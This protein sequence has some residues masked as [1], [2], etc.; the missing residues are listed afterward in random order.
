MKKVLLSLILILM[1][2]FIASGCTK[3]SVVAQQ[4]ADSIVVH[5]ASITRHEIPSGVVQVLD[6]DVKGDAYRIFVTAHENV[7]A[8]MVV[9]KLNTGEVIGEKQSI[10][11]G[12]TD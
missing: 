11:K 9:E 2:G 3:Q 1:L 6:I 12:Y 7:G 4:T 10:Q 8:H 5:T